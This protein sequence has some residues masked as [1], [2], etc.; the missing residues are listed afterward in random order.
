M[1]VLLVFLLSCLGQV[2]NGDLCNITISPLIKYSA[3]VLLYTPPPHAKQEG[4][5]LFKN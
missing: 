4:E 5:I 3:A 2:S 1:S